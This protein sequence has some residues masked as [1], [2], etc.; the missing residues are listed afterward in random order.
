MHA[1][2]LNLI[3][4]GRQAELA[5]A[6]AWTTTTR[7][8]S[9]DYCHTRCVAQA[10]SLNLEKRPGVEPGGAS[11]QPATQPSG[12]RFIKWHRRGE[13]NPDLQFWRLRPCHW[14]TPI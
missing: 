13:S 10:R 14:T 7:L 11:L 12:S 3:H 6:S 2:V 8:V 9:C 1:L 4:L 5:S